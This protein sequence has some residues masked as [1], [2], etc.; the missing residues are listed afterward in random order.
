MTTVNIR[1]IY[2]DL[3]FPSNDYEVQNRRRHPRWW[4]ILKNGW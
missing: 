4:F 1:F 3:V 2:L